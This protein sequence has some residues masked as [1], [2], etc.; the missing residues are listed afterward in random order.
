M[1]KIFNHPY[2]IFLIILIFFTFF[3]KNCFSNQTYFDLSDSEIEI[4][5]NFNGK[6]IIIFGLTEPNIDIIL[7]IK[8]P[9]K[10]TKIHKKER[11]FGLWINSKRMI[12]KDLPSIFFVASSLPIE[13][14]LNEDSII[15]KS[16][17]F[18]Q[19]L[20]NLVT[21]RN[22]N[23]NE[24]NKAEFWS[25][26]L[27]K[28]KKN[29]N[30]YKEYK[31]N[32]IDNKLFQTRV[33]FPSNTVPGAYDINIYQIYNKKII[34]EKSKKIQIKKTGLGNKIFNLAHNQPIFYG[35]FCILFAIFAGL[36]A[37]TLFRRL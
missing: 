2:K 24:K 1:K 18:E 12:Y 3:G 17:Y 33:F 11:F 10:N 37:A 8:G 6:E 16:L 13:E 30:F 27:I 28:I 25:K 4:Q 7:T 31:I 35:I 20:T 32:I 23:F 36:F 15:K 34:S 22:F 19:T 29:T 21:Q 9:N 26:N 5:T 14:I